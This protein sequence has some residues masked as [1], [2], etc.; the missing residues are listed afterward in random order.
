MKINLLAASLLSLISATAFAQK[1]ELSSAQDN[2]TKYQ[3]FKTASPAM[4]APIINNAKTSI[5]KAAANDKTANLPQTY[6]LKGAIYATLAVLDTVPAT[7]APLF[8]TAEEAL[9]KAKEIDTKGDYK[10]MIDDAN[11]NLAQSKL[12]EGVNEYKT[13]KYDLAYG[14]FDKYRQIM[15]DDT[16]AIYFTALSAANS[17]KY[18]AA[19]SNYNKLVTTKYS[20]NAA[21]YYDL[22]DLYLM[23][24]D[25]AASIK[26]VTEG[27]AKYPANGDLRRRQIELYLRTGKQQEVISLIQSAITNDPKNKSLYYYGGFT[28]TQLGD[29]ID[30]NQRKIKD[31]AS[32][33]KMEQTKLDYYSKGAEFYKK[34]LEVDPNYYEANLN[35]GYVLMKPGIDTYNSA[36]QLPSTKQKEYDAA[37]VKAGTQLDLAKPYLLKAVELNP[38]SVDAL[39]NLKTYYSGK[40]DLTNANDIQKK[41]DAL[42]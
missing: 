36:Q 15:P 38:K 7:S 23:S 41:I 4:A 5:D 16:N 27:V 1:S 13:K 42:K 37:V 11:R 24:K 3:A 21:I 30:A 31:A 26:A 6:A 29:I 2:Y 28:Y 12:T 10:A 20:Q 40:H 9:K 33:D 34:A 17:Q 32:R 18:D 8:V 25:T 19:I 22:S 35:I 39:T 14:S